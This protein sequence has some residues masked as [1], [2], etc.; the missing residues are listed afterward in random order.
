[1]EIFNSEKKKKKTNP[2]TGRKSG[3]GSG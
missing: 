1:M 3:H 2:G